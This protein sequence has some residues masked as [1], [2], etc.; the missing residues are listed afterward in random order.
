VDIHSAVDQLK[1][2]S[3]EKTR[4]LYARH[5]NMPDR[6]F[7]VSIAEL[8]VIARAVK[9]QQQ[10]AYQLY[11]TRM[12]EAMYLAG[13]VANGA[14]MTRK[15]L[16]SW[17]DGS[18]GMPMI[19]EYTVPWVAVEHAGAWVLAREWIASTKE[20]IAAAGWCT[21][22]GMVA[23]TDGEHLDLPELKSLLQAVEEQIHTAE[24]RV[25]YTMNGFII[26]VGMYVKPLLPA[27]K[28]SARRIGTVSVHMG[29]TDCKVPLASDYLAK[30][31]A[32]GKMG[33]KRKTI[34]C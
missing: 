25:R 11:E 31:E 30:A 1:A 28:A 19:S 20:H 9:G 12:L 17:A 2:K 18:A 34:R 13:M 23:I 21:F 6:I 33:R 8:K 32:A 7:G 10:L 26:A 3:N 22:A 29:D 24:N 15:H 16:Q 14:Q 27:A 5:G 4:I